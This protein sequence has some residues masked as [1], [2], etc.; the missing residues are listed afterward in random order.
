M[1][2]Y[3]FVLIPKH[4]LTHI[5]IFIKMLKNQ[6]LKNNV[7][8]DT[9]YLDDA[10]SLLQSV[11]IREIEDNKRDENSSDEKINID[12]ENFIIDITTDS[13]SESD[14]E[15][16]S[17]LRCLKIRT[18]A[19]NINKHIKTLEKFN[20]TYGTYETGADGKKGCYMSNGENVYNIN[21]IPSLKELYIT[22]TN[23]VIIN[24]IKCIL[25]FSFSQEFKEM[26]DVHKKFVYARDNDTYIKM[27][28]NVS[29]HK[30]TDEPYINNKM[31][32]NNKQPIVGNEYKVGDVVY[33]SDMKY[34]YKGHLH[35][36]VKLTPCKICLQPIRPILTLQQ[37]CYPDYTKYL[38]KYKYN[39]IDESVKKR[40]FNKERFT[41]KIVFND[42]VYMTKFI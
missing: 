1:R 17:L 33:L 11:R 31:Y 14:D 35:Q 22:N 15:V 8:T 32:Y 5:I 34:F 2:F 23:S 6:T 18:Y 16:P 38:Y 19:E 12:P 4:K 40:Y 13:D 9:R 42:Y 20:A 7:I 3:I 36:V 10:K 30:M 27:P 39:D 37:D 24:N 25:T 28:Q 26:S 41:H 29:F 21:G